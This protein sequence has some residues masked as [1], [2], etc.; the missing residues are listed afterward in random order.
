MPL[1]PPY[2]D[3][4][5]LSTFGYDLPEDR[6]ARFPLEKRESSRLLVWRRGRID[7][8]IYADLPEF[9]PS[10]CLLVFNDS[11]VVEARII[12]KKKSGGQIE[13]FCLEP[14]ASYSGISEAMAKNGSVL[15]T[16]LIGGASKW[17]RGQ[18]LMKN[19][20]EVRL[21]ARFVEKRQDD[22]IVEFSWSPD[23]LS[24]AEILHKM[25][26]VPLP[27]YLKRNADD[28]DLERYQTVYAKEAGSVAAPTAGLHFSEHLLKSLAKKNIGALY[29]TLHVGAGTF[30]PVKS[31]KI[32]GHHMHEEFIEVTETA[33]EILI[34]NLHEPVIAVGTTSLRTLETLYWLGLKISEDKNI[35][36]RDLMIDQWFP[37][38]QYT[39]ITASESLNHLLNWILRQPEKKLITKTQLFIVPGYQFKIVHGLVT[40]FH[41]PHSTLLLLVAALTGPEW[42]SAYTFALEHNFRFLSYGDGCLFLP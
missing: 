27:P 2:I 12:F 3:E 18:F 13:I 24:F 42:K 10:P 6:I 38:Q 30:M 36:G 35:S 9:L 22:F 11:R 16:C 15:W 5:S 19:K 25:G 34:A 8:G 41:Q 17:K 31:E 1:I 39:D 33:V 4:L 7:E 26:S 32:S 37:Y 21:V 23:N 20:D 28:S 14:H 29:L 40:N